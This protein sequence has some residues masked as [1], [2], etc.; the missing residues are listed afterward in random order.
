MAGYDKEELDDIWANESG[1]SVRLTKCN[2]G[3][4]LIEFTE[5][6]SRPAISVATLAPWRVQ[7]LIQA[8]LRA[9]PDVV[10]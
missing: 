6:V 3:A 9:Y 2:D 1:H 4:L 8:L 7:R 10:L 5:G